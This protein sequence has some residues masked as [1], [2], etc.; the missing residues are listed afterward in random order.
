MDYS[1]EISCI[2]E[3]LA[4][5]ERVVVFTGAGISTDS[6]IPDFRGTTGIY[7]QED[8]GTEYYLSRECLYS[9]PE[10]FFE[11]YRENMVYPYAEPNDGHYALAELE[12][13]G[14]LKAVITQN[15]DGLHCKA[16]NTHVMELHGT[17]YKNTCTKC[18]AKYD[19][20]FLYEQPQVPR[21]PKCGAIVRPDVVLYGEPLDSY[22]YQK[23]EDEI[24]Q[25]DVLIVAGSSLMVTPAAS[26]ID[27]FEGEHLIIINYSSTPYDDMAEYVIHDS[28]SDERSMIESFKNPTLRYQIFFCC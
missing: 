1:Y 19:L 21:C 26:L 6:G 12:E 27:C 4:S 22:V 13:N 15:I 10:R 24:A 23:A 7:N 18:G 11:F 8:G 17:I 16:G 28:I 25:A 5:A 20:D 14:K 3:I 9:E 2:K